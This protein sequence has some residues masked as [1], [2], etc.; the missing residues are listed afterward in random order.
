MK[1]QASPPSASLCEAVRGSQ[2]KEAL[3]PVQ[4]PTRGGRAGGPREGVSDASFPVQHPLVQGA[5]VLRSNDPQ[6]KTRSS[7]NGGRC[8]H[9]SDPIMF[10]QF[11]YNTAWTNSTGQFDVTH[12]SFMEA[13]LCA[14]CKALLPLLLLPPPPP[15]FSSGA[16]L[17]FLN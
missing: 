13:L 15:P 8:E 5:S 16:F 2:W 14:M 11:L 12:N 9:F 10:Q 17:H 1:L 3:A 4:F 7:P 6:C